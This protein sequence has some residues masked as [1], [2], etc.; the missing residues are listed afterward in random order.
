MLPIE[1]AVG[2]PDVYGIYPEQTIRGD[3]K[4]KDGM[5]VA[6]DVKSINGHQQGKA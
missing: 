2:L 5:V 4:G 1:H 6:E 3:F